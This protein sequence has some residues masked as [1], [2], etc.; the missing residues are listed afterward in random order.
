MQYA[1]KAGAFVI[2]NPEE[3][4]VPSA[5]PEL[6]PTMYPST[7]DADLSMIK[8]QLAKDED[9]IQY[10]AYL[11]LSTAAESLRPV[12][13]E[14]RKMIIFRYSWVAGG[15]VGF[16]HDE[17]GTII[18]EVPQFSDLFP[19]DWD[20]PTVSTEVDLSYYGIS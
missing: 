9:A 2:L 13:L 20:E 1:G 11:D 12:I 19:S 5:P 18:E 10:Y 3:G 14:A 17:N 16:V 15:L 4:P 7:E 6:M 8:D